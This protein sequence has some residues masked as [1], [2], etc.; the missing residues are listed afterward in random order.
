MPLIIESGY[1]TRFTVRG[2]VR[3]TSIAQMAEESA[4][5]VNEA[6]TLARG[7]IIQRITEVGGVF[8]T[9]CFGLGAKAGRAFPLIY[10]VHLY[11]YMR[12]ATSFFDAT[13]Y[14]GLST[15]TFDLDLG[16]DRDYAR[17]FHH[18]ALLSEGMPTGAAAKKK[19]NFVLHPLQVPFP[20]GYSGEDLFSTQDKRQE[21]WQKYI[22][23]NAGTAT[24]RVR[25]G[26]SFRTI[27]VPT[28]DQVAEER[29]YQAWMLTGKA[30]QWRIL[31]YGTHEGS[32]PYAPPQHF[33]EYIETASICVA[34]HIFSAAAKAIQQVAE[35]NQNAVS[36]ERYTGTYGYQAR[37]AVRGA[38]GRFVA[39]KDVFQQ[40]VGNTEICLGGIYG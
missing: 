13:N 31:Q 21:F 34:Q 22:Q 32:D 5:L 3:G 37:T 25:Q 6:M 30:P 26:T 16:N 7:E 9:A 4:P 23:S 38:G 10:R 28:Y 33:L 15:I 8:W 19:K 39:F 27:S 29:L 35:R 40:G 36:V 14:G 2:A 11:Q 1:P 18:R 24:I 17:G 12:G 20:P